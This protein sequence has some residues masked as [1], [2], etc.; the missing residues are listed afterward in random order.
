MALQF[1]PNIRNLYM[2]RGIAAAFSSTFSISVF[3]GIQP[4]AAPIASNWPAYN[5]ATSNFLVH[6]TGAGWTQ[7]SNGILLQLTEPPAQVVTRSGTAT[8]AILWATAASLAQVQSTTL[9]NAS[10]MVVP[11]SNSTDQGVIRFVDPDLV[12]GTATSIID[13][14]MG[15]Y[16]L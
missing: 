2:G 10:F 11:C 3:S 12:G 16:I 1:H 6:Y 9:P 8:W 5:E 14:S 4:P 7:P 13:G 15:A